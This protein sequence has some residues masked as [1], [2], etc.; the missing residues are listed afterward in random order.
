MADWDADAQSY[1]ADL[2]TRRGAAPPAT[3]GEIW[4]ANWKASGLDTL[5][6]SGAPL[7]EAFNN[8]VDAVSSKLG[9]IPQAAQQ[10]GLDYFGAP[11]FDGKARV[12]GQ[13]AASL[14][15]DQQDDIAPLLDIRSRAAD[16]AAKTESDAAD[17][18]GRTYGLSGHATSWLASVARQV[19][20]PANVALM[21]ATGPEAAG[22]SGVAR[23]ALIAGA[24]QLVQEP[25]I[26]GNRRELG[27]ESG[28]GRA[29]EDVGQVAGGAVA[30]PLL[31]RG[32]AWAL[33]NTFG[34]AMPGTVPNVAPGDF[35]AAA[36]VA[37]R[38]RIIAPAAPEKLE[39]TAGDIE[40]GKVL[41]AGR[42][43]VEGLQS[44]APMTLPIVDEKALRLTAEEAG[45]RDRAAELQTRLETLPAGDQAAAER[46]ARVNAVDDQLKTASTAAE[47]RVLSERRDELL[48]DTTPEQLQVSA[49]PL[50]QR[51]VIEA[52]HTQIQA[53]LGDIAAE[54]GVPIIQAASPLYGQRMVVPHAPEPEAL[55][56]SRRPIGEAEGAPAEPVKAPAEPAERPGLANQGLVD[57]GTHEAPAGEQKPG[58]Q[59]ITLGNP[60]LA[61]DAERTLAEAGGDFHIEVG[62]GTEARRVSARQALDEANENAAAVRELE[63]CIG[64]VTEDVA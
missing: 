5:T 38:D 8:L 23:Q 51:R 19:I 15:K 27:L 45:L 12:I 46:L 4:N 26:Q 24:G 21:V 41:E 39:T 48:A 42:N 52:E 44:T 43:L 22:I 11:G 9:P 49:A 53:R 13:L 36:L 61:A 63:D 28:I 33:R 29:I 60:Q 56:L 3:L 57:Q 30:L 25:V 40:L 31:F 35:D 32:A 59:K 47:R 16:A 2:A 17:V 10:K 6:G 20:D 54:R 7:A 55:P 37:D 14:P 18:A 50:E 58:E 64:G 1:S 62:E 34:R